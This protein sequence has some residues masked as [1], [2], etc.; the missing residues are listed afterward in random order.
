MNKYLLIF[1]F[2]LYNTIVINYFDNKSNFSPYIIVPLINALLVKYYFG[3]F[4][5]GYMWSLSDIYYWFGI[6]VVSIIILSGLKYL[7]YKL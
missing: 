7:R 3:D 4:D 2:L 6:V 5:K 1:I